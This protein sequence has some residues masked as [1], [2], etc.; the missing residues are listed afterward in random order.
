M[1]LHTLSVQF[2]PETSL[3]SQSRACKLACCAPD[4]V[5]CETK[6]KTPP[7]QYSLHPEQVLAQVRR[8]LAPNGR[9]AIRWAE[10][11]FVSTLLCLYS[12]LR[13]AYAMPSTDVAYGATSW[14]DREFSGYGLSSKVA[15]P[16]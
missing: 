12:G 8:V 10:L 4:L 16:R 2:A 7:L 13:S 3:I 9:I 11:G 5:R 6:S 15:C 1:P 14:T